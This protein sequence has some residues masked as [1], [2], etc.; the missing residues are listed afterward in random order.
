MRFLKVITLIFAC[1]KGTLFCAL[2]GTINFAHGAFAQQS[3]V[4][5]IWVDPDGCQHWV[6]DDGGEGYMTPHVT[7]DGRP[8]CEKT[9]L[10]A[11][12]AG[13]QLFKTN[14]A[15]LTST[16][17]HKLRSFFRSA[18]NF[19]FIIAGHTD[20]RASEIYNMRLSKLRASAVALIGRSVGEK[21]LAVQAFGETQ[22]KMS[23]A[24][25]AGMA[26]NRRVEIMCVS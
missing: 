2:L 9:S 19:Q 26:K 20:S 13:D 15:R 3:Y 1:P 25:A 17:K 11:E 5:G 14:S 24:T 4:P 6:M 23:N 8:V 10:C 21:I 18:Q 22:P 7:R 12:F 16:S